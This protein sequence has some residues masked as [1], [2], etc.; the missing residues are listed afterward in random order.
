MLLILQMKGA[1]NRKIIMLLLSPIPYTH[2]TR[3]PAWI[4]DSETP[5]MPCPYYCQQTI[6]WT[7]K[8]LSIARPGPLILHRLL[9]CEI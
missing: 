6:I 9:L 5:C 8:V 4:I 3:T 7:L 2:D 1:K